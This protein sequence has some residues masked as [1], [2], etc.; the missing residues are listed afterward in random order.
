MRD[1]ETELIATTSR[2]SGRQPTCPARLLVGKK[3]RKSTLY[4]YRVSP[5]TYSLGVGSDASP[6][7]KEGFGQR[8]MAGPEPSPGRR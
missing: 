2:S 7:A 8:T 6:P 5:M 4:K 3:K 1:V